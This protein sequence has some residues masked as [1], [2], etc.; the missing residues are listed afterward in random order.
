MDATAVQCS[1]ND[2]ALTVSAGAGEGLEALFTGSV[3]LAPGPN[4][5][6]VMCRDAAGHVSTQPLTVYFDAV[7]LVVTSVIPLAGASGIH[8]ATTVSVGFSKAI[9]AP[10]VSATSFFVSD[11][12]MLVPASVAV[13]PD[14][15][16]ATLTPSVPL[17]PGRTVRVS[18]TPGVLDTIGNPL[19]Q[20]F[21][22]QFTVAGSVAD[23]ATS[24]AVGGHHTLKPPAE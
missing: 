22:S 3:T 13:S 9:D 16:L 6:T 1:L 4:L 17:P 23:P 24:S 18:V 7:P 5:V 8:A 20:P 12:A 11:G 19:A 2:S 14:G 10:S 21:S 15:R